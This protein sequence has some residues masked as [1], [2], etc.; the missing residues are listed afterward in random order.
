MNRDALAAVVVSNTARTDKTTVINNGLDFAARE[1]LS[2]YLF[3][4]MVATADLSVTAG[5][6]LEALPSNL[7]DV[8]A[9]GLVMDTWA[10]P[11]YLKSREW[12]VQQFP[13]VA[14]QAAGTISYTWAD[15]SNIYFYPKPYADCKVRILYRKLPIAFA[16][17][18]TENPVPSLDYALTCWAT[19]FVYSSLGMFK[20][21]LFWK[22]EAWEAARMQHLS[23]MDFHVMLQHAGF[24][25]GEPGVIAEYWK[26]PFVARVIVG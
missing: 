17:G 20:S 14:G 2:R 6:L 19:F 10:V 11:V 1:L 16:T 7:M 24:L 26:S 4:E 5:D 18:S 15:R 25:A 13:D 3:R 8:L 22:R 23:D 21:A 9:V 12:F